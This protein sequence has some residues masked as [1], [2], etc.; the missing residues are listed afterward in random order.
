MAEVWRAR[1]V[2]DD[3]LVAVKI[4]LP[5]R[6][7][8]AHHRAQ[9]AQ[10]ASALRIFHHPHVVNV[11]DRGTVPQSVPNTRLREGAPYAVLDWLPHGSL[12][13]YR[14]RMAW[15][16]LQPVLRALLDA[17]GHVHARGWVHRDLKPSNVLIA[18]SRR[19]VL[20]DFGLAHRR[21]QPL[22]MRAGTPSYMAP[23]QFQDTW[24]DL[25]PWSDLYGFGCLA[26]TLIA[27][28]PLFPRQAWT[29]VREAHLSAPIPRLPD[30]DGPVELE[31]WL[32][33]LLVKDP[34][35][36]LQ[37]AADAAAILDAMSP[38][39]RKAD[40]S[41]PTLD[42]IEVPPELLVAESHAV[43]FEAD[44]VSAKPAADVGR[45]E[46]PPPAVVTPSLRPEERAP[47]LLGL[48][49]VGGTLIR[50][51]P[52]EGRTNE[53][54][55]L[56]DALVEVHRV[57]LAGLVLVNGPPGVGRTRLVSDLAHRA[58]EV[59]MAWTLG[60]NRAQLASPS[61]P[62]LL[63]AHLGLEEAEAA[64][65]LRV[66]E[67][68]RRHGTAD[69]RDHAALAA[70]AMGERPSADLLAALG[71][72]LAA[73]GARRPV[74]VML[75]PDPTE[76]EGLEAF[77]DW[78]VAN[79][80]RQP[81]PVL[82][83]WVAN[84]R[85][86]MARW[87]GRPGVRRLPVGPLPARVM[88]AV[89]RSWIGLPETETVRLVREA[90]GH[91]GVARALVRQA[92]ESGS[93][94]PL[95]AEPADIALLAS[96]PDALA[97]VLELAA[98]MGQIV[99]LEAWRELAA[100]RD[101][102]LDAEAMERLVRAGIIERGAHERLRF[103][104]PGRRRV[105]N[106]RARAAG[107]TEANHRLVVDH[108]LENPPRGRWTWGE[109]LLEAGRVEEAVDAWIV[110]AKVYLGRGDPAGA[111]WLIER[112]RAL[113]TRDEAVRVLGALAQRAALEGG[114]AIPA[115]P[116][117][118]WPAVGAFLQRGTPIPAVSFAAGRFWQGRALI[119]DGAFDEAKAKFR[120][121]DTESGPFG[122][123]GAV[124]AARIAMWQGD[125]GAS[126]LLDGVGERERWTSVR[127]ARQAAEAEL[128]R[129]AGRRDEATV[130]F[131]ALLN[132]L[133]GSGGSDRVRPQLQLA[134]LHVLAGRY[135][136]AEPLVRNATVEAIRRADQSHQRFAHAVS[137]LVAV[138]LTDA[139][140]LGE[141]T[142]V[143]SVPG[144][145]DPEVFATLALLAE[146]LKAQGRSTLG[147]SLGDQVQ[148][149]ARGPGRAVTALRWWVVNPT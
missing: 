34:A 71:R 135:A 138:G 82:V 78:V 140:R 136:E 95:P 17:L 64:D 121:L 122:G 29:A 35:R 42:P 36:R 75:E 48:R 94:A 130:R 67:V 59:G 119:R 115:E 61:L 89:V 108:Q 99:S 84:D 50:E 74:L 76:Q 127:F 97:E 4:L 22:F 6:V 58:H 66:A 88:R 125:V 52:V 90:A 93:H 85:R 111:A 126:T 117:G 11:H 12:W 51:G 39:E 149:W 47:P 13:R 128:A 25:G 31:A 134:V 100:Q 28:Q 113:A 57:P 148:A 146:M 103:V 10:E 120:S 44:P 3:Q 14:G 49:P 132:E 109:Q 145:A 7:D 118:F 102:D 24:R 20:A 116:E 141:A 32:R 131:E 123:L 92:A 143:L 1:H 110:A 133:R 63:R 96:I 87:S 79:R 23:E 2:D 9:F 21:G 15:P 27:G 43:E 142:D 41:F 55:A 144:P 46:R 26:W 56:W 16:A 124:W 101:V 139:N 129:A 72:H 107:R 33:E 5:H 53:Q 18:P 86:L 62:A 45:H 70:L 83:V 54:R 68:A 147:M 40:D 112:A 137:G 104:T 77:V 106:D 65:D 105:L 19:P 8:K 60:A 114:W 81:T 91:L 38:V 73:L 98:A 80:H 69:P 30:H 37:C